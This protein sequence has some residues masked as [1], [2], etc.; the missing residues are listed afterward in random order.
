[1]RN[2]PNQ[3]IYFCETMAT[4]LLCYLIFFILETLII[5]GSVVVVI[6]LYLPF[7][8]LKGVWMTVTGKANPKIGGSP[9]AGTS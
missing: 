1:M 2:R 3:G 7:V 6:C 4:K 8:V 9:V 5:L